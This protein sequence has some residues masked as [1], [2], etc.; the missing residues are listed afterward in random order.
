[1]VCQ[2]LRDVVVFFFRLETGSISIS[3]FPKVSDNLF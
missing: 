1:M 2:L 3:W